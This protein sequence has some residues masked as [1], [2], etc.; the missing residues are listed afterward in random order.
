[1]K[2]LVLGVNGFIGARLKECLTKRGYQV[3]GADISDTG[4]N[5]II[6]PSC[7]DFSAVFSSDDFRVCI[8]C[9]GAASV[10]ESFNNPLHDFTL[11][12]LRIAEML[13]AFRRVS[14][15][16]RFIHLSSAAVYGN[17]QK[18]PI[19]EMD[20]VKPVS[21]YGWH[22]LQAEEICR[23]Y[24]MVYG[25]EILSMR[26]FSAYGP[27]LRK[28][29]FWD[30]YQKALV[31]QHIELFGTGNETRDFIF[32]DDIA[33]CVDIFIKKGIFDGRAVNVA[34]GAAVT[35]RAAVTTL[36]DALN[37]DREISFTGTERTGDPLFWQADIS[38]LQELGYI[39]A[40]SLVDGVEKLATWLVTQ[41]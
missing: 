38:H 11:N 41:C 15:R 4:S 25:L 3:I 33:A 17:P 14:P 10:P 22:K 5:L 27:G 19:H 13:E 20:I 2:I 31:R 28:Q 39:P 8:N 1:M 9:T 16:T 26:V 21:P 18:F 24:A 35:V 40:F 37:W 12:T 32:I 23:E 29:L 36:L 34:S 30:V 7:P 6:D